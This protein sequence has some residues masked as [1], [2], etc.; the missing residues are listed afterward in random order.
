M[1]SFATSGLS[2]QI[3]IPSQKRSEI[4]KKLLNEYLIYQGRTFHL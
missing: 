4:A 2:S 1:F 3:N